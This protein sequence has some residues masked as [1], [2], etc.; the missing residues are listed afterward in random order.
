MIQMFKIMRFYRTHSNQQEAAY[1]KGL[2]QMITM[3]HAFYSPLKESTHVPSLPSHLPPLCLCW[4][5][6]SH[7][8]RCTCSTDCTISPLSVGSLGCLVSC[9]FINSPL[10]LLEQQELLRT[11]SGSTHREALINLGKLDRLCIVPRPLRKTDV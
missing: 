1:L 3:V 9:S 2:Y 11:R 10:I 8:I 4:R 7:E 6:Y 5:L